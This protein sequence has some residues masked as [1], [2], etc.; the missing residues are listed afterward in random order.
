MLYFVSAKDFSSCATSSRL[1]WCIMYPAKIKS[2]ALAQ[3]DNLTISKCSIS[4]L[5]THT[6]TRVLKNLQCFSVF[7]TKRCSFNVDKRHRRNTVFKNI[8]AQSLGNI[9]IKGK[10]SSTKPC[11]RSSSQLDIWY[12]T[13]FRP[14]CKSLPPADLPCIGFPHLR[15]GRKHISPPDPHLHWPDHL[16]LRSH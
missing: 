3:S 1:N 16:S 14:R 5:H 2:S 6:V 15:P 13:H 8:W 12:Q 11:L 4:C 7:A 9:Y 10:I